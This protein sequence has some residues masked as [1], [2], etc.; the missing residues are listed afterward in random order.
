VHAC[1]FWFV[2]YECRCTTPLRVERSCKERQ[3]L[4]GNSDGAC[5]LNDVLLG[6]QHLAFECPEEPQ[7]ALPPTSYVWLG[8]TSGGTTTQA[9]TASLSRSSLKI[10]DFDR[11]KS[12]CSTGERRQTGERRPN[13]VLEQ[14][15]KATFSEAQQEQEGDSGCLKDNKEEVKM[16]LLAREFAVQTVRTYTPYVREIMRS[17]VQGEGSN[18]LHSLVQILLIISL[19]LKLVVQS[20][21]AEASCRINVYHTSCLLYHTCCFS[22]SGLRV[23]T[24]EESTAN[25]SLTGF[26]KRGDV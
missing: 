16:R 7:T 26:R 3:N 21:E 8:D 25:A 4:S 12:F 1:R 19:R 13:P 18:S 20:I 15:A 14:G 6:L 10:H 2:V 23:M 11:Y 24:L 17:G 9:A 5:I 22:C